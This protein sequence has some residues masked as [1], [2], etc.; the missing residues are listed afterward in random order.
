MSFSRLEGVGPVLL[1]K[2]ISCTS[3]SSVGYSWFQKALLKDWLNAH[4]VLEPFALLHQTDTI[5][6]FN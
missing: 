5:D 2:I 4:F 1:Q 3:N 6:V